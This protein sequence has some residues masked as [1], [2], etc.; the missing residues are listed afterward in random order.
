MDI[1]G[2]GDLV[3]A[4]VR[5]GGF[6]G[7]TEIGCNHRVGPGELGNQRQPHVAGLPETVEQDDGRS[8]A[9]LEIV[10]P[11]AVHRGEVALDRLG[12]GP[13]SY[14]RSS[15]MDKCDATNNPSHEHLLGEGDERET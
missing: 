7:A 11:H 12:A 15:E 13:D 6:A 10:Q 3:V 8:A 5:N 14:Q 2:H 4:A 9:G 1:A